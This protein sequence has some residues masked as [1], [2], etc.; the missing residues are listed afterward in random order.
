MLLYTHTLKER[1]KKM[2][3]LGKI[4]KGFG[5]VSIFMGLIV[6]AGSAGDCDGACMEMANTLPEMLM[7]AGIGIILM[8]GGA[9]CI[10][11]GTDM[12]RA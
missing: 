7:I 8:L 9:F 5:V 10:L 12:D 6:A 2:N 4:F 3:T 11:A 1:A